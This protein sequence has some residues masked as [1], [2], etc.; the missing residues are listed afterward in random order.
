MRLMTTSSYEAKALAMLGDPRTVDREL[1]AFRK[2]ARILSSKQKHLLQ[3][4]S[5]KWIAVYGGKIAAQAAT[6]PSLVKRMEQLGIPRGRA[7]V[8]FIDKN[9]RKM[10]L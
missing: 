1:K 6:L 7:I 2:D 10:I 9:P 5:K 4:Y 3:Q 8:R